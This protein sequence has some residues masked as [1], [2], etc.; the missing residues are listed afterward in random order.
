MDFGKVDEAKASAA[1]KS[2][3]VR[4]DDASTHVVVALSLIAH[5]SL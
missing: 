4:I 3:S 1:G 2:A 5:F